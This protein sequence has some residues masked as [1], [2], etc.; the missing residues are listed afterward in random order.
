ML[1]VPDTSTYELTTPRLAPRSEHQSC[2]SFVWFV[3][4][5]RHVWLDVRLSSHTHTRY[6]TRPKARPPPGKAY[7][8]LCEYLDT[9][10]KIRF[11]KWTCTT[12]YEKN[13]INVPIIFYF[14]KRPSCRSQEG[15]SAHVE[16]LHLEATY[17]T[18]YFKTCALGSYHHQYARP[19]LPW[20]LVLVCAASQV[21][22]PEIIWENNQMKRVAHMCSGLVKNNISLS[23]YSRDCS[24]IA[25]EIV[26]EGV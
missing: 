2:H 10:G 21:S 23:K 5:G 11:I 26:Q 13:I 16:I 15:N 8:I 19:G 3:V 22:G 7:T 25:N 14:T 24:S 6:S 12:V 1:F 18:L 9:N 17:V 20:F 4:C